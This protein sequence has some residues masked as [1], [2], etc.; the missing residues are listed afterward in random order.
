MEKIDWK[1]NRD[2][3]YKE[4]YKAFG[5]EKMLEAGFIYDTD[6]VDRDVKE[7]VNILCTPLHKI[8]HNI[9]NKNGKYPLGPCVLISTG[10]FCPMHEGHALIMGQARNTMENAGYNVVGGFISP[11]H[12]EYIKAKT[13]PEWIPIH[14]RLRMIHDALKTSDWLSLDPWE[15]VFNKV[16]INFT[17]VLIRTEAYLKKHTGLN[18]PVFFV[19]GGDNAKFALTF[20]SQGHCVVVNRP[21]YEDR[22]QK[23]KSILESGLIASPN[24]NERIFWSYGGNSLSSTGVRKEKPFIP[25]NVKNLIL[26]VEEY[27]DVE[28]IIINKL[29]GKFKTVLQKKLSEQKEQFNDI[30]NLPIISIDSLIKTDNTLE[31]SR[32]YD[33]FGVDL[34][35]YINRP[36]TVSLDE[37]VSKI[38]KEK[39]YYIFDD[40]IHSGGTMKFAKSLLKDTVNVKGVFSFSISAADEGEILDC[41]DFIVNDNINSGL[42]IQLPNNENAR[43]P[44]IYPYVCPFNRG[45]IDNPLEF[46]IDIWKINAEKFKDSELTLADFSNWIPL[47]TYVGFNLTDKMFQICQWHINLLSKFVTT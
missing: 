40:D 10:S 8:T 42:V 21:G 27:S 24:V 2:P 29:K 38:E 1:I 39:S 34:I 12:D 5:E 26:R 20:L 33:M 41:R 43:A 17:D 23:Y 37:Q 28:P 14:Y 15:G 22:F 11:S 36:G 7:S 30:S 19:C 16:A 32:L 45:S 25:D 35:D 6:I 3:Y 47:F 9:K 46:S 18:I 4:V 13:G 31:I 44:Y